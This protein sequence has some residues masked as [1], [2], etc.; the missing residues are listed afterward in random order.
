MVGFH[1]A[2]RL[3]LVAAAAGWRADRRAMCD[4][5]A[6]NRRGPWDLVS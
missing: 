4:A 5:I 1:E 3:T 6:G 2:R